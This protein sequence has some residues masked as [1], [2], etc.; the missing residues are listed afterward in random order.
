[1]SKLLNQQKSALMNKS[2]GSDIRFR[3]NGERIR[4]H[5]FSPL[6]ANETDPVVGEPSWQDYQQAFDKGYDEG[7]VKG[8]EA[9]LVSGHEEGQQSG[10]AAGFNQGRIEGQHKGKDLI[11]DQLNQLIAP[12]AAIKSLLE[13]GHSQQIM[14]QQELILDLVRRVSIQVIRCE[15]TL[16]PQQILALV[17]ET[18]AAIPDDPTEVKIHLEPTAVNKLK[19]LAADKIQNWTLVADSTISAGGC[20]IVSEKSDADASMETR[21]NACLDQVENHLK[22]TDIEQ[23]L[24]QSAAQEP[25]LEPAFEPTDTETNLETDRGQGES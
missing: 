24:A 1:M 22:R 21:L 3:L 2:H 19:E 25:V 14:Q 16:Q 20:R 8:H 10:Y 18:L 17:E 4:R 15:L 13:E 9:G 23:K 6:H 11:D 5:Q 12:L 7:V